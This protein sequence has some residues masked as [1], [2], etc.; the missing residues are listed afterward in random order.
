MPGSERLYI[1]IGKARRQRE[2]GRGRQREAVREY[3]RQVRGDK[4]LH[5]G[6]GTQ[7]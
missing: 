6:R 7:G 4:R 5:G 1:A 3:K 2:K